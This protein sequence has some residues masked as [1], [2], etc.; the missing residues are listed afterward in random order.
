VPDNRH[1]GNP[2]V[3]QQVPQQARLRAEAVVAVGI[4]GIPVPGKID[5][6]DVV[7]RRQFVDHR[8]PG[9][10]RRADAVNEQDRRLPDLTRFEPRESATMEVAL[11]TSHDDPP[12]ALDDVPW[13][14]S[15]LP[16]VTAPHRAVTVILRT[17]TVILRT[18]TSS[19]SAHAT[20]FRGSCRIGLQRN[21]GCPGSP[22]GEARTTL[23]SAGVQVKAVRP[24]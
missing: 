14:L 2:Q 18:V 24:P 17:V 23:G 16:S 22:S 21:Q 19:C 10:R 11:P 15:D 3:G 6:D 7:G 5:G 8:R 4:V 9:L 20:T 13:V 12:R 1:G